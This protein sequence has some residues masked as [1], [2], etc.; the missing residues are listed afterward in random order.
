MVAT[1]KRTAA[2]RFLTLFSGLEDAYQLP[3]PTGKTN[4]VNGKREYDYTKLVRESLRVEVVERHLSGEQ[5]LYVY[6]IHR[7]DCVNFG[8]IDV[9]PAHYD[10]FDAER[11][12]ILDEI[13]KLGLHLLPCESKPGGLHLYSFFSNLVSAQSARTYFKDLARQLGLKSDVEI[14][15]KQDTIE[16]DEVGS[17]INLP[18]FGGERSALRFDDTRMTVEQALDRAETL[19]RDLG[20]VTPESNDDAG[21]DQDFERF[22][23][24]YVIGTPSATRPFTSSRV[25]CAI[26]DSTGPRSRR[27]SA[28][29]TRT[30]PGCRTR[31]PLTN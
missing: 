26:T 29:S 6:P 21:E 5:P 28:L 11:A 15:P 13:E 22:E 14:F 18:L 19:A 25:R 10:E 1:S 23:L 9:D 30:A 16:A 8:A 31:S 24:P 12:R 3:K 17:G 7:D 27:P 4:P 2:E 20:A